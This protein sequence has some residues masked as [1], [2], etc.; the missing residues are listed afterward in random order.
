MSAAPPQVC[1]RWQAGLPSLEEEPELAV[2]YAK[3]LATLATEVT[4]LGENLFFG[5]A[6]PGLASWT[7]CLLPLAPP[8][9][10]S[11]RHLGGREG[12]GEGGRE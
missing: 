9:G 1:A 12:G 4:L 6:W 3:L 5:L 8:V 2:K 7:L 11:L 10:N